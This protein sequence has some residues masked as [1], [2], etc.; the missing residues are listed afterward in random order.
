MAVPGLANPL[1]QISLLIA[2]F[3]RLWSLVRSETL[4]MLCHTRNWVPHKQ[5]HA[6]LSDEIELNKILSPVLLVMLQRLQQLP[7]FYNY[8]Y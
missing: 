2:E 8:Y 4:C 3:G 5:V 7:L 1:T 6:H